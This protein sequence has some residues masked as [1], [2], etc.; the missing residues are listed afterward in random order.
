MLE[1]SSY[2]NEKYFREPL[3][4]LCMKEIESIESFKRWETIIIYIPNEFEWNESRR[5]GKNDFQQMKRN[6]I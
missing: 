4:W 5:E 2:G 3:E 6:G 1:A